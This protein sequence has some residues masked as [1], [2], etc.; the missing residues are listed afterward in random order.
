M[1]FTE[2][3]AIRYNEK[4][5]WE[6]WHLKLCECGAHMCKSFVRLASLEKIF[7]EFK[8]REK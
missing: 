2:G 8:R 4:Y 1:T 5:G 6:V 7:E 3:D